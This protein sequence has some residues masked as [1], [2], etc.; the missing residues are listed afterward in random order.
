MDAV[1]VFTDTLIAAVLITLLMKHRSEFKKTNSIIY[2][3][4][5]YTLGTGLVTG[6]WMTIGLIGSIAMPNSCLY[7]LVE[8]VASRRE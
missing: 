4:I 7:I 1:A 6:I 5:M 8:I 3:L 2:R